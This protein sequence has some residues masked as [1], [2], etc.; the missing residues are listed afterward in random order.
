MGCAKVAR[1][2][3]QRAGSDVVQRAQQAAHAKVGQ[4]GE[5][6]Q[7]GQ[8]GPANHA[9]LV[10]PDLHVQRKVDAVAVGGGALQQAGLIALPAVGVVPAALLIR[11]RGM[12]APVDQRATDAHGHG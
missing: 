8:R 4:P 7:H 1:A 3:A 2:E 11:V 9:R 6:E 5:Q 10:L 12:A